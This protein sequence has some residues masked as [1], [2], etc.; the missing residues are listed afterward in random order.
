MQ[1]AKSEKKIKETDS[2]YII[3]IANTINQ[4]NVHTKLRLT[5][6]QSYIFA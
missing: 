6:L 3:I 4:I 1:I 2:S 5:C